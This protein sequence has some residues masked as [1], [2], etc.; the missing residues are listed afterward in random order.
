M[1]KITEKS[2]SLNITN[3]TFKKILKPHQKSL[4]YRALQIDET[5]K[6]SS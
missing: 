4:L 2:P 6:D 1:N 3:N 5:I